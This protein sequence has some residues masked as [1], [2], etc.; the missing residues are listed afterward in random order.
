MGGIEGLHFHCYFLKKQ[1]DSRNEVKT[2]QPNSYFSLCVVPQ[3]KISLSFFSDAID[4][5]ANWRDQSSS[6]IALLQALPPFKQKLPHLV[7]RFGWFQT[8]LYLFH[9][10]CWF[11]CWN[12]ALLFGACESLG[13]LTVSDKIIKLN[14]SPHA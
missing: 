8:I 11:W 10:E 9:D 5:V 2:F 14:L 6:V 4:V 3:V 1:D 13:V 7:Q 12:E